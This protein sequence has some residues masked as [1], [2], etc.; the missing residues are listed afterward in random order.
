MPL[1][2]GGGLLIVE[3]LDYTNTSRRRV[4]CLYP[5]TIQAILDH[6]FEI[7]LARSF[8]SPQQYRQAQNFK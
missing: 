8:V 5:A 4:L 6:T 7:P 2:L 1:P 3:A